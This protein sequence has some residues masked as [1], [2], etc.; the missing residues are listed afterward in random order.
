MSIQHKEA[1]LIAMEGREMRARG[2]YDAEEKSLERALEQQ[3][4][5]ET[6]W[7][8]LHTAVTHNDWPAVFSLA[9]YSLE[10]YVALTR[11]TPKA[12]A[13]QN[14][15]Q[16]SQ[17]LPSLPVPLPLQSLLVMG[18][19]TTP[20]TLDISSVMMPATPASFFYS[21]PPPKLVMPSSLPDGFGDT[22]ALPWSSTQA[23]DGYSFLNDMEY[24]TMAAMLSSPF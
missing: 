18:E 16:L 1:G 4:A 14:F 20:D 24:G 8:Q 11:A 23:A 9:D 21:T 3:R 6:A 17:P 19:D 5:R 2:K 7:R 13:K 10:A 15:L 12:A 22:N